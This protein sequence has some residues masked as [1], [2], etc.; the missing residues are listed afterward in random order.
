VFL[1]NSRHPQLCAP[2]PCLRKSGAP[3]SR[4]YGGILPSSFNTVL[5]SASVC[6]TSPPVSVWGTVY[7][8]ALFPGSP[9]PPPQS[10]KE[11]RLSAFVTSGR[12]GNINPIPI[13]YGCRPRLRGPA[14]PARINLAQEPLDLRREGFSPSLS[15]LM[16]AFSLPIPPAPLAG[17]LR[18]PTERSATAFRDQ[19][20]GARDQEAPDQLAWRPR[21]ILL[22]SMSP[23]CHF[24]PNSSSR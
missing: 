19:E 10:S 18:R 24:R 9:R 3:F 5:S 1:V 2:R 7:T 6:S 11:R 16:S 20:P 8:P 22:I 13:G 17:H 23:S 14:N 12:L 21:S 15:L 4:S